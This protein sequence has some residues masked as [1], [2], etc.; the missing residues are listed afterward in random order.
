VVRKHHLQAV[1]KGA[2][3]DLAIGVAS[4]QVKDGD[5]DKLDKIAGGF[6][7]LY[8]RGL[9]KDDEYE[10]DRMG[11][12]IAARAGYDPYGLPATLQTLGAMNPQDGSL[13]FLFKTHPAPGQRLDLIDAVFS[14]LEAYAGQP[15]VKDRFLREVTAAQKR[16]AFAAPG[17]T[18]HAA[19]SPAA[20][21]HLHRHD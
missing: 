3:L 1:R 19:V 4:T 20:A 11:L 12:V 13:A 2:R 14:P 7:E 17:V 6:K 18:V 8:A 16:G 10:A 15:A 5:R 21:R 9:D